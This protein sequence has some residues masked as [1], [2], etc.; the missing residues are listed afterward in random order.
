MK[1]KM[2]TVMHGA[3]ILSLASLIAKVLSACYRIPFENLVGNTGFYVYQQVYPIY[4]IGMTF[5]LTGF[6]VFI[7]KLIAE[8]ESPGE[9]LQVS[10]QVFVILTVFGGACWLFLRLFANQIAVLM[11]DPQ[12]ASLLRSVAWMFIFMPILAVGR[13][14][15]QGIFDMKPTAISQVIEQFVR[16]FV[17]I[18][19]ALLAVHRH[20][21]I[22]RMGTWAMLGSTFGALA[23]SLNFV[24][25]YTKTI[26]QFPHEKK[27]SYFSLTK[28]LFSDGLI[29]CLFAAMMVLLQLVDSFTVNNSLIASG[30]APMVAKSIKGTYDRAQPLVQLGMVVAVSFSSTLLPALTDALQNGKLANFRRIAK[31]LMR[32]SATIAGAATCGMIILMPDINSMLFGTSTLSTTISVYVVS[33]LVITLISTYNSILQS[34]NQFKITAFGLI[35]AVAVKSLTNSFL[36]Q[37]LGIIG[38]SVSTVLSLLVALGIVLCA[39][40]STVKN[41]FFNGDGFVRKLIISLA[42]MLIG[43]GC[44]THGIG[45][46]LPFTRKTA[47]LISICGIIVGAGLFVLM[48]LVQ[49]MFTIRE[50]LLIPGGKKLIKLMTKIK[51]RVNKIAIR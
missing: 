17:I 39:L 33:V 47:I 18:F 34:L 27:Q 1:N 14:Y 15:Y 32:I 42:V 30:V 11:G 10:R 37:H 25:F 28:R 40:P 7:S 5:A 50:W 35:L 26:W 41:L 51:K 19:V 4:G 2:K 13:G 8:Q 12:L 9:K 22:Y 36:I 43:V 24:S 16:V 46:L 49:K 21:T 38:A 31:T 44:V 45:S 3:L 48:I 23:A 20:W 6:P 29:I